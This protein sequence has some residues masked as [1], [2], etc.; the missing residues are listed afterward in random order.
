MTA[1]IGL[2]GVAAQQ[3]KP[4]P[5]QQA[6]DDEPVAITEKTKPQVTEAPKPLSGDLFANFRYPVINNKGEI[7]FLGLFNNPK[8]R[9]GYGQAI[10]IRRPDAS[11]KILQ[12]G[13]K[14]A[15]H[16]EPIFGFSQPGFNDSGDLAF[17]ANYGE[18]GPKAAPST[19][20]DPNDPASQIIEV[21]NQALYL[22]TADGIKRLVK[23]GEEVPN[24]PSIFSGISNVSSN[25]KGVTTFIGTYVDPDGRG[26]FM[27]E[28][29]KLKLIVRSGQRLS[30]K[31][32][33]IFSEHY[34]PSHIN[35]RNEVAVL[36]FVSNRSGIFIARP[37]GLEPV[38]L[39][40]Q[41]TPIKGAN[42]IGFGS[43]TPSLNDNG[44]IVFSAFYDGPGAGR[45]LFVKTS[46]GVQLVAKSG[47]SIE[48]TTYNFTD[49]N[50]PVINARGQ[51]AFIGNY[52][53]RG[54]GIFIKTAKGIEP[55]AISD[56]PVPGGV[57][58]EV[59]NNFTR[60]SINDRGE[61]VFYAQ[62]KNPTTGVDV[63]IYI[64]DEKGV[65]KTLVKRGDK[66]P[67]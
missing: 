21:K 50:A 66:M 36:A 18:A 9:M 22:K 49:F 10:F 17:V 65:L 67:N 41:P 25:S 28:G 47:S 2:F 23:Y 55:I 31:D 7:A 43:R 56:Q 1:L 26:M 60:P 54:R 40:G 19:S 53:G 45:G 59:F 27:V 14:A 34:Y 38:A 8:G 51:I 29:G 32:E 52:G 6:K 35:E 3:Q 4:A 33:G 63:G 30:A 42:Y 15:D 16:P 64:R 5:A 11:W 24:M 48:G 20:G 13:E 58:D 12:E 39:I 46:T 61:I 57:K 37:T 62:T 44:E